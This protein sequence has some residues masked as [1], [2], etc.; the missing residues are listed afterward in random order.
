MYVCMYVCMYVYVPVFFV[1][2]CACARIPAK[3]V[4]N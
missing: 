3:L 4:K 1:Y 2:A